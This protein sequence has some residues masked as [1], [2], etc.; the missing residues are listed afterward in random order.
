M[1]EGEGERG[2][3]EVPFRA[4]KRMESQKKF[5]MRGILMYGAVK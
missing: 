1:R 4:L 3:E 5:K 2:G